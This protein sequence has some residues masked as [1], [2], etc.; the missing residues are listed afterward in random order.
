ML[1]FFII[2]ISLLFALLSVRN[3]KYS[4]FVLAGLLPLYLIRFSVGIPFTLLEVL[5]LITIVRWLF[6]RK[7][8]LR[9]ASIHKD[10]F[11]RIALLVLTA[12]SFGVTFAPDLASALGQ[13]KAYFVEPIILF[14]IYRTELSK[15]D[16][17]HVFTAFMWSAVIV[18][19]IGILQW[20]FRIGI[21][22]PWDIER[23]ITSIFPYPNA[24]G[25]Y[26]A[27][28]IGLSFAALFQK[29]K[30]LPLL[31]ILLGMI[32][33]I[34]AKTEAALVTIPA[35]LLITLWI[36]P[37]SSKIK[38]RLTGACLLTAVALFSFIPAVH[39]KILLQDYSGQVRISQWQETAELLKTTPIFGS[40]LG[41]YQE[42]LQP[43][44]D[45]TL[46]EIFEYPHNIFLNI[47]TE[48]GLLGLFAFVLLSLLVLKTTIR[49][50]Y[51]HLVLGAFLALL[52]M[53][54]HGLVDVPYFKNDLS[55]MTWILLAAIA[56]KK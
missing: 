13:W 1:S 52:I 24:L 25:L 46:Y 56:H 9:I 14:F 19:L 8:H 32:A 16:W 22:I 50:R 39:E 42:A 2:S 6:L 35:A 51:D 33:I 55:V 34:L 11:A 31:T 12:A 40:G 20:I 23:R 47:W 37:F 44:H 30:F 26:I 21:P 49:Y 41:G 36:G 15:K 17:H 38:T 48:L 54:I 7:P 27:P 28:I 43:F 4:L 18:S 10:P 5:I 45:P 3:F 29:K 53:F